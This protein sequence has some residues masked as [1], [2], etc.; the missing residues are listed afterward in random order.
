MLEIKELDKKLIYRANSNSF[1]GTRGD[2]SAAS[3]KSYIDEVISWEIP[4]SKKQKILDQVY[5]KY[6]KI[7]EYEASHVS[8]MVARTRKI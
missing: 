1:N 6:S 7:L 2:N 5:S 4:E 8:A 3:Y